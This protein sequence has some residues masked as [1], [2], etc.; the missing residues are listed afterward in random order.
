VS[1]LLRGQKIPS[2]F[3]EADIPRCPICHGNAAPCSNVSE[4]QNA[5]FANP[6]LSPDQATISAAMPR[7]KAAARRGRSMKLASCEQVAGQSS[8]NSFAA[9]CWVL[10]ICN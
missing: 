5:L 6:F 8:R 1:A 4:A 3:P 7:P 10:R 2:N 9:Q